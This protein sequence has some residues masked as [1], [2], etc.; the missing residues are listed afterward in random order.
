MCRKIAPHEKGPRV[1][2]WGR[3]INT[4]PEQQ[5][6]GQMTT[7]IGLL[8]LAGRRSLAIRR[9]A[10]TRGLGVMESLKEVHL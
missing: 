9:Q 5:S 8:A 1:T 2:P 7:K 4:C 3:L 10:R 6:S